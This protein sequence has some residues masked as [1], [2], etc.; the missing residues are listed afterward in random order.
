MNGMGNLT[1]CREIR[2]PGELFRMSNFLKITTFWI[3]LPKLERRQTFF[4]LK[5]SRMG[6]CEYNVLGGQKRYSLK[7]NLYLFEVRLDLV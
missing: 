3:Y 7:S 1:K 5:H 6:V 2:L 4:L